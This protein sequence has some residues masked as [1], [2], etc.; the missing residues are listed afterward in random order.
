[1]RAR[2]LSEAGRLA[3]TKRPAT[4]GRYV[5]AQG[6]VCVHVSAGDPMAS[7]RL[8]NG[9]VKEHR[10]V[11]ARHLGRP[12]LPTETVHHINGDRADNRIEN[13]QL[14]HGQHGSGKVLVCASCG[15]QDIQHKEL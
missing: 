1:V 7:M 6:Y 15:S 14:R 9:Y 10:L 11:M 2:A 3:A 13:L 12:L 5:E 8:A 4:G